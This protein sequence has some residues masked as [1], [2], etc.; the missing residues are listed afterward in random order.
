M[1]RLYKTLSCIISPLLRAY[2]YARCLYGKDRKESVCNRFGIASHPR[3]DGK[4]LWIHAASIGESTAAL[5]FIR[6]IK[7]QFP[8][9]N[10]L[11]TTITVT[12]ADVLGPQIE[13]ISNCY[14]Q[15]VVADSPCWVK[16]FL[17]Y[18]RVDVAVFMESE[19]W[20][21][22]VDS[23]LQRGIPLFLLSARLSPTAFKRW[24]L[25]PGFLADILKKFTAIMAQSKLDAQRYRHFS[26]KNTTIMDN[27][28][29]ANDPPPC[30]ANLLKTFQKICDGKLV[31]VAASTHEKEEDI[32]LE[33]HR[34]LRKE[35]DVI[36]IIIPRHPTRTKDVAG[37]IE[38]HNLKFLLRSQIDESHPETWDKNPEKFAATEIYCIDSFGEIGTFF[39]LADVC[40]VGGTLVPIGGHNIYEPVSL[41][42]PV[43][44][45][46]FLDNVLAMR[47][48][49]HS[50][51]VAFEIHNSDDIYKLCKKL[52]LDKKLRKKITEI[53][54]KITRNN[55]LAKIDRVM[56]LKKWLG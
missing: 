32:L 15:Y 26:P 40:F 31:L 6:H 27:L 3:P 29:Y 18:W 35:F 28:K 2:F 54:K 46:P 23:L 22:I 5:T 16:R 43:I 52:F 38:K 33:A 51:E 14:H 20:P 9:L 36:S 19:I 8:D 45:G 48:F 56:Q 7:K 24:S 30:N 12:S 37:V 34:K 50:Q 55:A 1:H 21:N 4:L 41:G 11:I 10:I 13:K 25:V 49:L 42:K 17:D 53:S 44:H 39:R 47:D